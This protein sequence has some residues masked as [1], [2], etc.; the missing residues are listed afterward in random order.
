M[1]KRYVIQASCFDR[2]GN[3][4]S[5]AINDYNKSSPFMA[6]FAK[7]AGEPEKVYWHAE[8]LAIYRALKKNKKIDSLVIVRYDSKGCLKNSKPCKVCEYV[9]KF[10][11]VQKV[12][13]STEQGM[14]Q[15]NL[16]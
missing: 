3:L 8:C 6:K 2:K 1:K 9:C 12:L 15:L 4:L 5:T 13:Y 11:G 14:L 10:F 7:L 16:K